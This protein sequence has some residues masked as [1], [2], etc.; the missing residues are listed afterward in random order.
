M[1]LGELL[2]LGSDGVSVVL[3][4]PDSES[5]S[6]GKSIA[7][8]ITDVTDKQCQMSVSSWDIIND[9]IYIWLE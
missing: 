7:L 3:E 6:G 8:K 5:P 4:V 9:H 2:D 1:L